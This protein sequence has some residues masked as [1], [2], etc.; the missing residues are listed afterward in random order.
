MHDLEVP[1]VACA[2]MQVRIAPLEA[3]YS[4]QGLVQMVGSSIVI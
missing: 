4:G 3:D 2:L 1:F